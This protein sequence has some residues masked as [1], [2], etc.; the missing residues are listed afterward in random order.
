VS[1]K[2]GGSWVVEEGELRLVEEPTKAHP[3]GDRARGP[4]GRVL[5]GRP[6]PE[7]AGAADRAE[8]ED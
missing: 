2:G 3:A 5:N 6:E 8:Q 1:E 4:D 7:G